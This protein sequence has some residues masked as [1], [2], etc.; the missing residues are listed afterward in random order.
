MCTTFLYMFTR[1]S[2]AP[3]L[4][5]NTS[6]RLFSVKTTAGI[7]AGRANTRS[8]VPD[9]QGG[10]MGEK[11]ISHKEAHE[12]PVVN[13]SFKIKSERQTGHSELS[14]Q[15]LQHTGERT[16][17]NSVYGAQKCYLRKAD[18]GTLQLTSRKTHSRMK[19]NS[20]SATGRLSANWSC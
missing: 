11:V 1:R 9:L 5:T 13:T 8:H 12:H 20:C 16:S 15:I 19:M 2:I 18:L 3:S 17:E 14:F 10:Q 6:M 7:C 4:E